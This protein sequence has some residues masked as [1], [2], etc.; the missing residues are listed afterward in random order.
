MG[1]G[2][3]QLLCT[4]EKRAGVPHQGCTQATGHMETLRQESPIPAATLPPHSG[5]LRTGVPY[6]WG[7]LIHCIWGKN[8]S[9]IT[10]RANCIHTTHLG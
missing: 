2:A 6:I 7:P 10:P 1:H 9:P 5:R 4:W 8:R 3:S